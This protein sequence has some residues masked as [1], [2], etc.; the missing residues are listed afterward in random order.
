MTALSRPLPSSPRTFSFSPLRAGLGVALIASGAL[1]VQ[2]QADVRVAEAALAAPPLKF[3]LGEGVHV[4]GTD[5]VFYPNYS[6]HG[7]RALKVTMSC[8]SVLVVGP[9]IA[10]GG[11]MAMVRRFS[12]VRAVVAMGAAAAT[13]FTINLGRIVLIAVATRQFGRDGFEVSHRV[14]G[15]GIVL[16]AATVAFV[17]AYRIVARYA[18]VDRR[19]R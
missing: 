19:S 16:A 1:L 5:L 18:D 13:M 10:M 11:I 4:P 17:V 14:V 2:A 12:P 6:G 9:M 8:S 3:V 7:L 15:S